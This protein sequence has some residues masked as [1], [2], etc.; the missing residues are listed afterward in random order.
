[1]KL[2]NYFGII[3]LLCN[4]CAAQKYRLI[5]ATH[6]TTLGGVKGA[7]S[8]NFYIVVNNHQKLQPK[9]LLTGTVKIPL[10]EKKE[11]GTLHL[12][13]IYKSDD[14]MPTIEM[15]GKI[16]DSASNTILDFNN[17]YLISEI[18]KNKK[19]IKQKV[20]FTKNVNKINEILVIDE[21]NNE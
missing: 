3:F 9:Y 13:G 15:S 8:E 5:E 2:I 16:Q 12:Y 18:I 11:N 6:T 17:A 21:K 10:T 7:K 1:M 19:Q 4:S 14:S 20:N